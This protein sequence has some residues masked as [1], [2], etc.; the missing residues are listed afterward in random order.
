MLTG[1]PQRECCGQEHAGRGCPHKRSGGCWERCAP[2]QEHSHASDLQ[3]RNDMIQ[4][5]FN[6]KQTTT[7]TWRYPLDTIANKFMASVDCVQMRCVHAWDYPLFFS[8]QWQWN[9]IME[10]DNLP[11]DCCVS[12]CSLPP[13]Q[14]LIFTVYKPI[15]NWM[16]GRPGNEANHHLWTT[17]ML[18]PTILHMQLTHV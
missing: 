1:S 14:F 3:E 4:S 16:V 2:A 9:M 15:R 7:P 6:C 13:F 5:E 10:T 11:L 18:T 12:S 8:R 17:R